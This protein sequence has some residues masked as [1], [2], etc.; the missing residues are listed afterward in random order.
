MNGIFKRVWLMA[1][2]VLVFGWGAVAQEGI[3]EDSLLAMEELTLSDA[4]EGD[5]PLAEGGDDDLLAELLAGGDDLEFED[6]PELED[7][8]EALLDEP[9]MLDEAM[10]DEPATVIEELPAEDLA[11]T[12]EGIDAAPA[13]FEVVDAGD[14]LAAPEIL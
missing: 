11:S 2:V 6:A 4:V 13:A 8:P 1:V 10:A 7:L 5:L 14:A 3:D 12:I 9:L